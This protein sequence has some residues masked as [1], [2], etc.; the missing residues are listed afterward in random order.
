[1]IDLFSTDH[2]GM[3]VGE[4]GGNSST[5]GRSL[6]FANTWG[7]GLFVVFNDPVQC[8]RFALVLL[9]KVRQ[10]KWQIF[11]LPPELTMRV[12]MH[13]GPV[14]VGW[15]PVVRHNNFFGPHVLYAQLIEPITTPGC[16]FATAQFAAC[17]AT[18][19]EAHEFNLEYIGSS[20]L[21]KDFD[22]A[23]YASLT[24]K[25]KRDYAR[26][27]LYN[28]TEN[29]SFSNSRISVGRTSSPL[30][31]IGEQSI[32]QSITAANSN[33]IPE[34]GRMR[35][36]PHQPS[37]A[38]IGSNGGI[39]GS[40]G[41][42]SSSSITGKPS[43]PSRTPSLHRHGRV[44]L[45]AS[46][47]AAAAASPSGSPDASGSTTPATPFMS[48]SLTYSLLKLEEFKTERQ[49]E[50]QAME[51][52]QAAEA[53]AAAAA[54]AAAAATVVQDTSVIATSPTLTKRGSKH[55]PARSSTGSSLSSVGLNPTNNSA[56]SKPAQ[57]Q[58]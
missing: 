56:T 53:T 45:A 4:G 22:D 36:I 26:C 25:E 21:E 49:N 24:T 2:P 16:A 9:Q 40:V 11:G 31:A 28:L 13:A 43:L 18:S 38:I 54:V 39:N 17:L 23:D 50:L 58:H 37:T 44:G 10:T 12:G 19:A 42:S 52:R 41:A 14:L 46:A 5:G 29:K 35:S 32:N 55:K 57:T 48:P 15:D 8:S 34:F 1:V 27:D 7:D 3:S 20:V 30:G 47:A 6:Q 33:T 51:L